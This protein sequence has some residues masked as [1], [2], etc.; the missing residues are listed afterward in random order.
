[1]DSLIV[2]KLFQCYGS[3]G[4]CVN[5]VRGE[6]CRA[7]VTGNYLFDKTETLL[8]VWLEAQPLSPG[9]AGTFPGTLSEQR[10]G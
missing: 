9:P 4:M 7:R 1:M 6:E 3:E 10:R 8:G 2:F 5:H